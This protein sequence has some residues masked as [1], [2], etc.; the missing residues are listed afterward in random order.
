MIKRSID[1]VLFTSLFIAFGAASLVARTYILFDLEIDYSIVFFAFASTLFTYNLTKVA[2]IYFK[3]TG[4]DY[5]YNRRNQ[6]N[7]EHKNLLILLTLAPAIISSYCFF[8]LTFFQQLFVAHIGLISVLY[9]TPILKGKTLRDIPFLKIFLIAYVWAGTSIIP[10]LEFG[11]DYKV[12]LLFTENLLFIFAI[13][14]PFDIRDYARDKSQEIKTIPQTIGIKNTKI[15]A[16]SC[17]LFSSLAM[18]FTSVEMNYLLT[19]TLLNFSVIPLII[20]STEEKGEYYYLGLVD[21]ALILKIIILF[22]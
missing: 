11:F 17:I 13:T 4:S 3:T 7:F 20:Y 6:W 5:A 12:I 21:I 1:F 14:L 18:F 2:P 15:V 22:I 19:N 8:Q 9:T 10:I 16:I